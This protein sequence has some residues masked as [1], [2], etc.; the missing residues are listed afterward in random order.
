MVIRAPSY[1]IVYLFHR[2][3]RIATLQRALA[4][5]QTLLQHVAQMVPHKITDMLAAGSDHDFDCIAEANL[6]IECARLEDA[7]EVRHEGHV[8]RPGH[9]GPVVVTHG[10]AMDPGIGN[11]HR[12]N[13]DNTLRRKM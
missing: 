9:D 7:E 4:T 12:L 2:L 1:D 11:G 6:D 3:Y 10:H 13:M 5:A 8:A